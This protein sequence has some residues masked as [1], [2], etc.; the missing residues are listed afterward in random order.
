MITPTP[1]RI[2]AWLLLAFIFFV[3]VSPI[4]LRPATLT[5]V[6]MD[7][8]TAY[9]IAGLLFAMAYPRS[10][11]TAAVLLILGSVGFELLQ[12]L[13][14]TRHARID[15]ALVKAAGSALGIAIGYVWNRVLR[16]Q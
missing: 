8:A 15:D 2:T 14:P 1:L 11:K 9:A 16:R 7:R 6:N 3:T 4:D 10:W 13:Q 5:S 12:E